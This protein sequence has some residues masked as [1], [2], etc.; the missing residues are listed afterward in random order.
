MNKWILAKKLYEA[1][2]SHKEVRLIWSYAFNEQNVG[3][4]K[5]RKPWQL[6]ALEQ[7]SVAPSE[8]EFDD[9]DN[10]ETNKYFL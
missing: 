4:V 10:G 7:I 9:N 8:I 6:K 1:G 5:K 2:Y 3:T